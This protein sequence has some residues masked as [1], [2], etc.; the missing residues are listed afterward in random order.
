MTCNPSKLRYKLRYFFL[1]VQLRNLLKE[2]HNHSNDWKC[3]KRE[4]LEEVQKE[5]HC[6]NKSFPSS[7]R[8]R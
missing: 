8:Q 6:Y 3:K 4:G 2:V 7:P 1:S 5:A